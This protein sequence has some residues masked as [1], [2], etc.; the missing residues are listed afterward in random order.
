MR[1]T[2]H[3]PPLLVL[4]GVA[5]ELSREQP[6]GA[7]GFSLGA[8]RRRA[9]P[10]DRRGLADTT[11]RGKTPVTCGAERQEAIAKRPAPRA[12]LPAAGLSP[13]SLVRPQGGNAEGE[14]APKEESLQTLWG[15]LKR[16]KTK[17]V[18]SAEGEPAALRPGSIPR[19]PVPRHCSPPAHPGCSAATFPGDPSKPPQLL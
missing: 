11:W 9:P 17:R 7:C 2:P 16:C 15:G 18:T 1:Q 8:V 6:G 4:A 14:T 13:R 3:P 5:A 12:A 19:A 10:A